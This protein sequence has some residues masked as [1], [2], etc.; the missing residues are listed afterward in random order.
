MHGQGRGSKLLQKICR[1]ADA[2]G[3]PIMLFTNG[4]EDIKFYLK[5][6]FRI[7]GVTKSEEFGFEN[8]YMWYEPEEKNER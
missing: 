8:T 2:Q 6:G 7:F 1:Y 5:N 4:E 3:L